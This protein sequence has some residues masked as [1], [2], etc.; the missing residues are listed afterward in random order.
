MS[1]IRV[2]DLVGRQST[3][4]GQLRDRLPQLAARL[5]EQRALDGDPPLADDSLWSTRGL[6]LGTRQLAAEVAEALPDLEASV[7]DF[8][9][10]D[11]VTSPF[12]DELAKR[13]PIVGIINANEDI[14]ETWAIVL[15]HQRR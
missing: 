2:A 15:E 7:L 4:F 9:D 6:V 3:T 11:V 13:K 10:V 1:A 14:A 12:L 5:Q 8:D